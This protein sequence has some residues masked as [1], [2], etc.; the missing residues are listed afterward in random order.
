[1]ERQRPIGTQQHIACARQ[2]DGGINRQRSACSSSTAQHDRTIRA[3]RQSHQ[4]L[5][6]GERGCHAV[7]ADAVDRHGSDIANRQAVGFRQ[8]NPTRRGLRRHGT[9]IELD[10]VCVRTHGS[11]RLHAQAAGGD[12]DRLRRSA[13]IGVADGA[14][15]KQADAALVVGATGA[16]IELAEHQVGRSLDADCAVAGGDGGRRSH[17]DGTT[18]GLDIHRLPIG[19]RGE[20]DPTGGPADVDGT[21]R[22]HGQVAGTGADVGL[23]VDV[24][25]Q[26]L[27][28]DVA[29]A[30]TGRGRADRTGDRQLAAVE[31][32]RNLSGGCADA[33]RAHAQQRWRQGLDR[34]I[35]VFDDE[36]AAA[37][38]VGRAQRRHSGAQR[39]ARG[40]DAVGGLQRQ[41]AGLANQV[42]RITAEVVDDRAVA[43]V[44]NRAGTKTQLAEADVAAGLQTDATAAAQR[45]N[46]RAVG[47]RDRAA[48]LQG[49][50]ATGRASCSGNDV[51]SQA[52]RTGR[53]RQRDVAGIGAGCQADTGC[54][55]DV[56][57]S[58]QGQRASAGDVLVDDQVLATALRFELHG[59]TA[60]VVDAAR[61]G[62]VERQRSGI[63]DQ[64]RQHGDAAALGGQFDG[65]AAASPSLCEIDDADIAT[66]LCRAETTQRRTGSRPVD[67]HADVALVRVDRGNQGRFDRAQVDARGRLDLQIQATQHLTGLPVAG[68]VRLRDAALRRIQLDRIGLDLVEDVDAVDRVELDRLAG[69]G[70]H[71]PAVV[72]VIADRD[73]SAIDADI[74]AEDRVGAIVVGTQ[75]DAAGGG[76]G[77]GMA[78]GFMADDDAA[79]TIGQRAQLG[80]VEVERVVAADAF[81]R[82]DRRRQR[83]GRAAQRHAAAADHRSGAHAEV[84]LIAF[85]QQVA[86]TVE[87]DA[88]GIGEID[89]VGTIDAQAAAIEQPHA[90]A[91][92]DGARRIDAHVAIDHHLIKEGH[93]LGLIDGQAAE[94]VGPRLPAGGQRGDE[95]NVSSCAQRQLVSRRGA[96]ADDEVVVTRATKNDVVAGRDADAARDANRIV[97]D[98]RARTG[99]HIAGQQRGLA[100]TEDR[101]RRGLDVGGDRDRST[102]TI[103][104]E[105][106]VS[107]QRD[108]LRAAQIDRVRIARGADH[109]LAETAADIAKI[110][111]VEVERRLAAAALAVRELAEHD[112]RGGIGR[113]QRQGRTR[114]PD[115]R[116]DVDIVGGDRDV[117]TTGIDRRVVDL[118]A[119][120]AGNAGRATAG[121]AAG[122][123]QRS[124]DLNRLGRQDRDI[125]A[126][127]AGGA[128]R[129]GIRIDRERTEGEA[130]NLLAD[131][132]AGQQRQLASAG[133]QVGTTRGAQHSAIA[134]LVLV[135]LGVGETARDDLAGSRVHAEV[136][137]VHHP[138][139]IWIEARRIGQPVRGGRGRQDRTVRGCQRDMAGTGNAYTCVEHDIAPFRDQRRRAALCRD[140]VACDADRTLAGIEA[141]VA[142]RRRDALADIQQLDVA[143]LSAD[144]HVAARLLGN[145]LDG[146]AVDFLDSDSPQ[147]GVPKVHGFYLGFDRVL[148]RPDAARRTDLQRGMGSDD[149]GDVFGGNEDAL[150]CDDEIGLR[151]CFQAANSNRFQSGQAQRTS[152]GLD[153][154]VGRHLEFAL[155]GIQRDV[156]TGRS[157]VGSVRQRQTLLR[158]QRDCAAVALDA[159]QHAD[160]PLGRRQRH[161]M[162]L[163]GQDGRVKHQAAARHDGHSLALKAFQA[164]DRQFVRLVDRDRLACDDAQRAGIDHGLRTAEHHLAGGRDAQ[165]ATQ[166]QV[167]DDHLARLGDDANRTCPA[168]DRVD[169]D[170]AVGHDID[171]A[172]IELERADRQVRAVTAL[173]QDGQSAASPRQ[174][175][176]HVADR[177]LH[178][179]L[180]AGGDRQTACR[181]LV[182][183]RDAGSGR[184][185]DRPR[186][187]DVECRAHEQ[188]LAGLQRDRLPVVGIQVD[189]RQAAA[190]VD[191]IVARRALRHDQHMVARDIQHGNPAVAAGSR[192]RETLV[193]LPGR[194]D[195]IA[196]ID[197]GSDHA[198]GVELLGQLLQHGVER[199]SAD[200][201][202]HRI[203]DDRVA[204]AVACGT[205]QRYP[206]DL[207]LRL[208]RSNQRRG[209]G[210]VD[211]PH[212]FRHRGIGHQGVRDRERDVVRLGRKRQRPASHVA[213]HRDQGATERLIGCLCRFLV[214]IIGRRH[215]GLD[216]ALEL[217]EDRCPIR[218][219]ALLADRD[220]VFEIIDPQRHAD[221]FGQ[222]IARARQVGE[223]Q[224]ADLPGLTAGGHPR[225]G[226][227]ANQRSTR[228]GV[229]SVDFER[230]LVRQRRQ[231]QIAARDVCAQGAIGLDQALEANE[232]L[233]HR[234][235]QRRCRQVLLG[236][237]SRQAVEH[238]DR[239]LAA[240]DQIG[241][242]DCADRELEHMPGLDRQAAQVERAWQ[243]GA[244]RGH[245]QAAEPALDG[246]VG[247]S[248]A[249]FVAD[250]QLEGRLSHLRGE[251]QVE[252]LAGLD[253]IGLAVDDHRVRDPRL[254][255]V[256]ERQLADLGLRAVGDLLRYATGVDDRGS[257]RDRRRVDG[258]CLVG[259]QGLDH[260]AAGRILR[261]GH[262][263]R[264][265]RMAAGDRDRCI[266]SAR[267]DPQHATRDLHPVARRTVCR[268]QLCQLDGQLLGDQRGNIGILH[269]LG[270][271]GVADLIGS[272]VQ[273]IGRQRGRRGLNPVEI[274]RTRVQHGDRL[275][276][277]DQRLQRRCHRSPVISHGGADR[278]GRD[279]AGVELL[280]Q[281]GG[282]RASRVASFGREVERPTIHGQDILG[283]GLNRQSVQLDQMSGQAGRRKLQRKL[284]GAAA[285]GDCR[286]RD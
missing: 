146:H 118:L 63:A 138:L 55:R 281:R 180:A 99:G 259:G 33:G 165:L 239:L 185:R 76:R 235:R 218:A 62:T 273:R 163:T 24:A 164:S 275:A 129:L 115:R 245:A 69:G 89:A 174:V 199:G 97:V 211:G 241:H 266:V 206:A 213:G 88:A 204:Q 274:D 184:Q 282:Q 122:I 132:A 4:R 243:R 102:R 190:H 92:R 237:F 159:L 246:R 5:R 161:R 176:R 156:T 223:V 151:E 234:Q 128:D 86:A 248:H 119:G 183:Q 187:A 181:D 49:H 36:D 253:R 91:E 285:A 222:R 212:D 268:L 219:D 78:V 157:E 277:L 32:Q 127:A 23:D 169:H 178:R 26:R 75:R 271:G 64:A 74:A 217:L 278:L 30:G 229:D 113:P 238:V 142:G 143:G 16:G 136:P 37:C 244:C 256:S 258:E 194:Q 154:G 210:L 149:V 133:L 158:L 160:R 58:R 52:N 29:A 34:Q 85:E 108:A 236:Q 148:K 172:T 79:E 231:H 141:D 283:A 167:V 54:G 201:V 22:Q 209:A 27:Q 200:L 264:I 144:S 188:R 131:L 14:D 198:A 232:R 105:R 1:M 93:V 8:V 195:Q 252:V 265:G 57:G 272:H 42:R 208:A 284:L 19:Q 59:A 276:D 286:E 251:L 152:S 116:L 31:H 168:F 130:G 261:T 262:G 182:A 15:G 260:Q 221:A 46:A 267:D 153:L 110:R 28:Q 137:V 95:G 124:A 225:D 240:G 53:G 6:V 84:D 7:A 140:A 21:A 9:D 279:S 280:G 224:F 50:Q 257:R 82:A 226:R 193:G 270:R 179:Q 48:C 135:S 18:G 214:L 111:V 103:G 45:L 189:D 67:R 40:T 13:G 242:L 177:S 56:V 186:R 139:D 171:V 87:L 65:S 25:S 247:D 203:D 125:G 123:R 96:V 38:R 44:E 77:R 90:L 101:Q 81:G 10:G 104:V 73:R 233:A 39:G 72:A 162:G 155:T 230:P 107:V 134:E 11:A 173:L 114:A 71:N 94:I 61:R 47:H 263:Q 106:G 191:A 205:G 109:E 192:E 20:P 2:R 216:L 66:D 17:R 70:T 215:A 196:A 3:S 175:Q 250:S 150:A 227:I 117:V 207:G 202:R 98:L 126:G 145:L 41:V 147:A 60:G 197:R 112:R 255:A 43:A 121:A 170:I 80:H 83:L 51:A 254:G 166:G 249:G 68:V 120:Q 100:R 220:G 35:V 12:V 228:A 269:V